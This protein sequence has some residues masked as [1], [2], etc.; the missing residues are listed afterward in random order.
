[1]KATRRWRW[2]TRNDTGDFIRIWTETNR[3]TIN[4][5]YWIQEGGG[6]VSICVPEFTSAT[7]LK[8]AKGAA[9][10]VVFTATLFKPKRKV[11]K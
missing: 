1:M 10:K 3:P 11:K 6:H 4:E 7:G 2:A 9:V 5:N 8:I